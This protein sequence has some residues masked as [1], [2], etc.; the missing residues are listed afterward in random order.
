MQYKRVQES[1]QKAGG[2]W[3]AP[4]IRKIRHI[5]HL[6]RHFDGNRKLLQKKYVKYP[7]L[8]TGLGKVNYVPP[9]GEGLLPEPAKSQ[10]V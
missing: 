6:F 4:G 7:K 2:D 9:E 1:S 10:T 8:C 5:K 3:M